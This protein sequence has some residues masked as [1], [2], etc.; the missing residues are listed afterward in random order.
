MDHARAEFLLGDHVADFDADEAD[1]RRRYLEAHPLEPGE[2]RFLTTVREVIG[3][4][5]ADD[6][7]PQVWATAQR[8]LAL[9]IDRTQVHLQL[10]LAL[11]DPLRK[12]IAPQTRANTSADDFEAVYLERLTRLPLPTDPQIADALINLAR[13]EPG[14]HADDATARVLMRFGYDRDD[15]LAEEAIEHVVDRLVDRSELEYIAGD[16]L[17]HPESLLSRRCFTHRLNDAEIEIGMLNASFDLPHLDACPSLFLADGRELDIVDVERTQCLLFRPDDW[18]AE[19]APGDLIACDLDDDVL[20]LTRIDIEPVATNA[21]LDAVTTALRDIYREPELPIT[22]SELAMVLAVGGHLSDTIPPLSE[23]VEAVGWEVRIGECG[24]D[25]TAWENLQE[26]HRMH[27]LMDFLDHQAAVGPITRALASDADD[28]ALREVLELCSHAEV[29]DTLAVEAQ[30][31]LELPRPLWGSDPDREP[32]PRGAEFAERLLGLARKPYEVAAARYVAALAAER[33]HDPLAADAHLRL[34]HEADPA[35]P[36]VTDRLAWCRAD[37]GDAVGAVRLWRTLG[38][39]G[40]HHGDLDFVTQFTRESGPTPGRNEPCWCGSGRK[41]KQCHL[42]TPRQVALH[43]R[44]PWL[45]RKASAYLQRRGPLADTAILRVASIVAEDDQDRLDD[46]LDS[47]IPIDLVLTEDGWFEEF[48]A[49]RGALLPDDEAMLLRAW[50]LVERSVYEIERTE[51]GTLVRIRDLRTGERLTVHERTFSRAA[52][53]GRLICARA[54]PAGDQCQFV[55]AVLDVRPGTEGALLDLLDEGDVDELAAWIGAMLRPPE[56]RTREDELFVDGQ[57]VVRVPVD[58]APVLDECYD[59]HDDSANSWVEHFEIRRDEF[60]VR[61][62][63]DLDGDRLTIHANSEARLDRAIATVLERI[64]GATLIERKVRPI[65]FDQAT[66][67]STVGTRLQDPGGARLDDDTARAVLA[68]VRDRFERA[69]CDE[70]VP[71]LGGMTPRAAAA[72]PTR[73]GE[74]ERLIASFPTVDDTTGAMRPWRLREL[75]GLDD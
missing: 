60:V 29:A 67:P 30:R 15:E 70:S 10:V 61:S 59:Q 47:P 53:P 18:L 25:D 58:A 43:E 72:D 71:A 23:L 14:I 24:P 49:D 73:R 54:V 19:F 11:L 22:G 44:A 16:G 1:D 56:L 66:S 68:Q 20:A 13:S 46:L 33:A 17:V 48:L 7:P 39:E 2:L 63:L 28:D 32:D 27:R 74:L 12:T 34:A 21:L 50:T 38:T 8:L 64:D 55:G 52:V 5:I 62:T 35:N 31:E 4:Q 51:P 3:N 69:W 37:R 9:G 36:Y 65:R 6:N 26:L 45:C 75:L 42:G 57:A 40:P 41:F